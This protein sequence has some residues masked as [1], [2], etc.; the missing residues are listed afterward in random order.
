MMPGRLRTMR[1]LTPMQLETLASFYYGEVVMLRSQNKFSSGRLWE[2]H[3]FEG[4]D[5]TSRVRSL[6]RRRLIKFAGDKQAAAMILTPAGIAEME[7]I[8]A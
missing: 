4:V 1:K 3:N 6:S 7:A 2:F 8:D 5:I